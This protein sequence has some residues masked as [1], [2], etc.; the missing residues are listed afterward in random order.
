MTDDEGGEVEKKE[1][2]ILE[3][4]DVNNNGGEYRFAT[5]IITAP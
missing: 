2:E 4:D 3:E 1:V 5:N